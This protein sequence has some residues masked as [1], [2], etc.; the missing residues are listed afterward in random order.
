MTSLNFSIYLSFQLHY[1]H[2]VDS[3]SNI[4]EY[5]NM[6]LERR[7]RMVCKADNLTTIREPIV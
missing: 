1:G 6:F 7:E 2:G 5:Q 4:N 3:A